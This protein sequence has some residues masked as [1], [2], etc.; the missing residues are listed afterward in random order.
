MQGAYSLRLVGS[1]FRSSDLAKYLA[2]LGRLAGVYF[3]TRVRWW[4]TM[5]SKMTS[6]VAAATAESKLVDNS[7]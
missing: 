2:R 7:R 3:S 1:K 4:T 5:H 6:L